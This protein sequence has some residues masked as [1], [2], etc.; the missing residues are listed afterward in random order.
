MV[1]SSYM[2]LVIEIIDV[3]K[4]NFNKEDLEKIIQDR[5]VKIKIIGK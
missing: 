5:K 1:K 3:Y 2:K 4:R